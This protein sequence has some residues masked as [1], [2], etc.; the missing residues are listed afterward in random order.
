MIPQSPRKHSPGLSCRLPPLY[1]RLASSVS[2]AHTHSSEGL[3]T[4]GLPDTVIYG[5]PCHS[6]SLFE[7]LSTWISVYALEDLSIGTDHLS[8]PVDF[9]DLNCA[10]LENGLPSLLPASCKRRSPFLC[11]VIFSRTHDSLWPIECRRGD[12][13]HILNLGLS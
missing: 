8:N 6:P 1:Q 7:D 3:T 4:S 9:Q 13:T 2:H 12:V 11:S 10:R 5:T